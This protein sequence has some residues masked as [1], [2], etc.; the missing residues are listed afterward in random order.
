M[1]IV[2]TALAY[3]LTGRLGLELAIPPGYATAVWPPSGIALAAM[4]LCGNRVW[5]G[6]LAG[7]FLVNASTGFDASSST[8][9][10]ASLAIPAT[11]AF[12]ATLQALCGACLAR[13]LG[14]FP[15]VLGS[16]RQISSLLAYGGI[17]GCVVNASIGTAVLYATGRVPGENA[18]FT[19]MT[20]WVGDSIGV[21]VFTP[22]VLALLMRP[23]SEWRR[24][25]AVIVT[26]TTASFLLAVGVVAYTTHLERKDFD[27]QLA[28]KGE[29]LSSGL[30]SALEARLYAVVAVQSFLVHA[31]EITEKE[32]SLFTGRL[33]VHVPGILALE[34]APRVADGERAAFEQ[35]MRQQSQPDFQLTERDG[36]DL[37]RAGQRAEY[38]PIAF[39]EP[40][41][42]SKRVLGF[43]LGSEHERRSALARARDTGK[44]AVTRRISL[45]RGGDAILAAA[46]VFRE[47]G[48]AEETLAGF[49]VG[50]LHLK[51]LIDSAFRGTDL[52][53]IHFWLQ[54]ETDPS[55]PVVLA[56]NSD[57]AVSELRWVERGLFGGSKG[58]GY[59]HS[60]R[61][62]GR[63]WVLHVAPTQVFIAKHRLHDAWIVL[64]GGLLTVGLVA[65]FAMVVTGREGELRRLVE[66]RTQTLARALSE[67]GSSEERYRILFAG[68]KVPMLL[69][70]PA[71]GT[72]VDANR[73]AETYYG[74][75]PEDLRRRRISDINTM[76]AAEVAAT[77]ET[78]RREGF[79]HFHFQ[80]R[81]AN[82]DIRDVEVHSGPV[83]MQGRT[84]LYSIIHDITD[85]RRL[86]ADRRRLMQA[87]EQSPSS[88]VI[89]DAAG[90]VEY[91]NAAF[92][93]ITGYSFAEV[94]GQ[95]PRILKSGATSDEE[96]RAMWAN[97]TAGKDWN[98][99][100]H[101]RRKDGS[102][103]WEQAR[104]SPVLDPAG[105]IANFLAIKEDITARKQ[106]EEAIRKLNR[107]L[108]DILAAASE[109]AIIATD[110]TGMISL[111]NRGAER[112]L[113]Y[114]ASAVVACQ[115]PALFHCPKEMRRREQELG[116]ALGRPVTGFRVLVEIAE[117]EGH[118]LR[119]WTYIRK[120][121]RRLTASLAVT[122]VRADDGHITGYLSVA[123]DITERKEA[124]NRVAHNLAVTQVLSDI[125][126]LSFENVSLTQVLDAALERVLS[127][128]W[129]GLEN[130]GCIFLRDAQAD[131]LRMVAQRNI[132]DHIRTGCAEVTV[133]NCHCGMAAASGKV[134]FAEHADDRHNSAYVDLKDHGHYCVPIASGAEVLGVLNAY[135]AAGHQRDGEEERFLILVADTLAGVIKRKKVEETLRESRE[136][137]KTLINASAD[138]AFLMA[139]DGTVLAANEAIAA[140]FHL[141]PD[142][143]VGLQFFG[144]C[145]D[146]LART[147]RAQCEEV[148]RSGKP[149]HIQDERAG[150]ILENR[151]YPLPDAHGA[152]SRLAVF[153]RD[154]TEQQRAERKI[155]NLAAYQRAILDNTPIGI[156]IISTNRRI[157][158]VNDAFCQVY[159]LDRAEVI[160]QT[161]QRL[162]ADPEQYEEIGRLAYPLLERG[163]VYSGEVQMQ[164]VDGSAV[165]ARLVAHLVNAA[166]PELGIV[167]AAED[168]SERKAMELDLK[169]SNAELEQFAYVASHDL[170]QPLRMIS[171]YLTL[172]ERK[173][174]D[175]LDDDT[176]EFMAYAR[177]GAVRMDRLILDLLEYSRIGR[178][179]TD[180][181]LVSLADVANDAVANLGVAITEANAAV[182]VA[183]G[184]PVVRG[185]LSDLIR[186]FQN[187]IGNAVKYRPEDRAPV[188][189]VSCR[190]RGNAWEVSVSDNGIGIPP[191]QYER[192]FGVF[193]RLHTSAQ[194]EGTGIGLAVCRKIVEHHG[195]R[196]WVESA[197]G[198][199]SVFRFTLP[200]ATGES[201]G[202]AA[203]EKATC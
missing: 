144:L 109:V 14:G 12:G 111:F 141:T 36:D 37:K 160:G 202:P 48:A 39:A 119:E 130:Q 196:I 92:S 177:D 128:P 195:G 26:A 140:R 91:V 83:A 7:S 60:F 56:T 168:I 121:G 93:R 96:Y 165:W 51:D 146:E 179:N 167:W 41:E 23:R 148:V 84:L 113:G 42:T 94:I 54:D 134:V 154:I 31:T 25:S 110:P 115:T 133:G 43:D 77:L 118:E 197:E 24:R 114:D 200:V 161:T 101:N 45:V 176:R 81:L 27:A 76:S 184:L 90:T 10:L 2:I 88:V 28:A 65:A 104:I 100:F 44:L 193:Q 124:E 22:V 156:A 75:D 199:G 46:P 137:A 99:L 112:M 30:E 40:P 58:L 86:E 190:R 20:W 191:E 64:V 145:S 59:H 186:L 169:R 5:P 19:W 153:S 171:S 78:A 71:D 66:E 147:R 123:Q 163:E 149:A 187:L 194:Y 105:R 166:A 164:R 95:N 16:V 132:S 198:N 55:A 106:A 6:I 155:R 17:A 69:L 152:V 73:A 49:A 47:V 97:L 138:A 15:N 175:R 173:L 139:A 178:R 52:S 57:H 89:T 79:N 172:T 129:L 131:V 63:H 8:A 9:A 103:Y 1:V 4:L 33:R 50:I 126:R 188:V 102:L 21:F 53:E 127:L 3:C 70:D 125:L 107:E 34:W 157:I 136:L 98:G 201:E 85:R 162:Y 108:R 87:I 151:I 29:D 82:G 120:D 135:V 203:G 11:V 117:L 150:L 192:I 142:A 13:R 189:A 18:A 170:R 122:P 159:G 182:T 181:D 180:T 143:M 80:H 35:R 72:I 174:H 183:P 74:Y 158:D 67:L 38:F 116:T 185:V 62:G 61:V 68:S 32:F